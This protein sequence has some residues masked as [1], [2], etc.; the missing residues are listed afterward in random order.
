MTNRVQTFKAGPMIPPF[1]PRGHRLDHRNRNGLTVASIT[2]KLDAEL[3]ETAG[4]DDDGCAHLTADCKYFCLH[5]R[6]YSGA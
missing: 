1:A 3:C 2:K 4:F 6:S 5:I